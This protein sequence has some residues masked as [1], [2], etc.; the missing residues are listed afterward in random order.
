[1]KKI[2]L[3][4][5]T[6]TILMYSFNCAASCYGQGIKFAPPIYEDLSDKLSAENPVWEKEYSTQYNGSF[7]CKKKKN[8]FTYT[9]KLSPKDSHAA[10]FGFND[11]KQWIR[12]QITNSVPDRTL[13]GREH[14]ASELNTPMT[15]RYSLVSKPKDGRV[16]PG[17]TLFLDDVLMVSDITGI[18]LLELP[19]WLVA[20]LLK[21]LQWLLTG[22]WPYDERDM[23]GQ[24]MYISY[25]PK[26]TTCTFDNAGISVVLP[27]IGKSQLLSGN[28]QGITPFTLN[29]SCKDMKNEGYSDRNIDMFLSS[30][31]LLDSDRTVLVNNKNDSPY[32]VGLRLM[33]LDKPNDAI[34]MSRSNTNKG[35]ATSIFKVDAGNR[36]E[37]N[38]S[39]PMAAYYYAYSKDKLSQGEISASATLNIVYP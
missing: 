20:Q 11:G 8:K 32:G 24:P 27:T 29:F 23:Y 39:I 33:K 28:K 31:D 1:M 10:I 15:I 7:V 17:S 3:S 5:A 12:A 26:S 9:L 19:F 16:V 25:A 14:N 6:Y 4:I 21:I 13:K 36:L 38:F 30:N 22:N 34:I 2:L 18:G 35:D 37:R